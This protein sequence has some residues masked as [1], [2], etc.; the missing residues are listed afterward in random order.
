MIDFIIQHKAKI[1]D[2]IIYKLDRNSFSFV[3][4]FRRC[5]VYDK[6]TISDSYHAKSGTILVDLTLMIHLWSRR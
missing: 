6:Y 5:F 3:A 1:L 2:H 4:Y